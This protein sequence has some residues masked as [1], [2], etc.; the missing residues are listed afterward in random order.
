MKRENV[1]VTADKAKQFLE[2]NHNCRGLSDATWR[3]Y[4]A[5]MR[6]GEWIDEHQDALVFDSEGRLRNG[7]HRLRAL[8]EA[9]VTI[10]FQVFWNASE[11][12]IQTLDGGRKRAEYE[13]YRVEDLDSRARQYAFS[14]VKK[15]PDDSADYVNKTAYR[16]ETALQRVERIQTFL[17]QLRIILPVL[18]TNVG[19]LR[20]TSVLCAL[21][22]YLQK[23]EAKAKSFIESL[24]R[25]DGDVQQARFLRDRIL[26]TTGQS[27]T[28]LESKL[29]GW[30]VRACRYHIMGKKLTALNHKATWTS[31]IEEQPELHKVAA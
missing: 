5:Q 23:D 2:R 4:A 18:S 28:E 11:E 17:H 8:I 16:N 13:S 10:R 6:R 27:G 15:F 14:I 24:Y 19:P 12:Y 25:V 21:I 20:K 9:N 31:N 29:Y 1:S 30:T 3:P 22:K 26:Q 7:Q